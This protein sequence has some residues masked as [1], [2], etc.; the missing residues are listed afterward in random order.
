MSDTVQSR[1]S[2]ELKK[3]AE[4]VLGAMGLKTSD[5]IRLFL[6][7]TVNVGGLPFRPTAPQP[8]A[9]TKAAMEEAENSESL[10]SYDSFKDLRKELDV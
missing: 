8:N 7:Q 4:R 5:A 6:Q 1:I 9:A 2:P 3:D 10:S